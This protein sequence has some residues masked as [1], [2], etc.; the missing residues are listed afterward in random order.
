[1]KLLT[2]A[3]ENPDRCLFRGVLRKTCAAKKQDVTG[4]WRKLNCEGLHNAYC[5]FSTIRVNQSRRI[6]LADHIVFIGR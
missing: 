4:G 1:V 2:A 3:E 5:P 6:G